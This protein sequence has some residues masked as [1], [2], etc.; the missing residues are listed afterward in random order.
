MILFGWV[1]AGRVLGQGV[2]LASGCDRSAEV[3][4]VGVG[5]KGRG[6]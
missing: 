2:I 4:R 3:A 6:G 1:A 5:S